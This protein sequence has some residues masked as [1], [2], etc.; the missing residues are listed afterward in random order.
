MGLF[1]QRP[2]EEQNQWA[3]LPSEPIEVSEAERLDE[4]PTLDLLDVGLGAA[5]STMVFPVAP[6]APEAVDVTDGDP[7][8]DE[9]DP[10]PD[11]TY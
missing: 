10:E 6:P 8:A 5:Y 4:A 2:E 7:G 9:G 1:Q 11:E 3:G